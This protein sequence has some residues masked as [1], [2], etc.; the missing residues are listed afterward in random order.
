MNSQAR[1]RNRIKNNAVSI[2]I[3]TTKNRKFTRET[4][5]N[6]YTNAFSLERGVAKGGLQIQMQIHEISLPA[7]KS[8]CLFRIES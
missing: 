2:K 1:N 6:F 5:K 7:A 3:E 4:T 8:C